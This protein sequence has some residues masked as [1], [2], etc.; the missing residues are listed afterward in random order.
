MFN[1]IAAFFTSLDLCDEKLSIINRIT[2]F[3]FLSRNDS[4]HSIIVHLVE[5]SMKYKSLTPF[6]VNEY[7]PAT[8][9]TYL[10]VFFCVVGLLEDYILTLF[11]LN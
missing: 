5:S 2:P 6:S 1:L 3:G 11:L 9:H 8:L 7:D 4:K 10:E